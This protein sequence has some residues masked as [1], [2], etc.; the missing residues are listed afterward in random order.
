[1][2]LRFWVIMEKMSDDLR[3]GIAAAIKSTLIE[4]QPTLEKVINRCKFQILPCVEG[5]L[6]SAGYT[7]Q[8]ELNECLDA[9]EQI[10]HLSQAILAIEQCSIDL[11]VKKIQIVP[12]DERYQVLNWEVGDGY[13]FASIGREPSLQSALRLMKTL[14]GIVKYLHAEDANSGYQVLGLVSE[15]TER[16]FDKP[17]KIEGLS[18]HDMPGELGEKRLHYLEKA[19]K[20]GTSQQYTYKDYWGAEGEEPV[21]WLFEAEAIYLPGMGVAINCTRDPDP[22][23]HPDFAWQPNYWLK[24]RFEERQRTIV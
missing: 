10:A 11:S 5:V 12:H 17:E 9:S 21:E 15:W 8:V 24:K 19:M 18:V 13:S 3:Q 20:S 7:L 22:V 16:L 4:G 14:D 6:T 2:Y 1:M 23:R